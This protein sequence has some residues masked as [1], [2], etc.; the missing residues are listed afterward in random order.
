MLLLTAALAVAQARGDDWPEF[1]GPTG[2]GLVSG[3]RLPT[4]WSRTENVVWKQVIPGKGWSSPV[5]RGERVYLT[6]SVSSQRSSGNAHSLQAI[7]LDAAS[8]KV[9]WTKEVFEEQG[10]SAVAI[11]TK[12]SHASPT[13]LVRD[14]RVYVHFGHQ[15]T[16]CLDLSGEILWRNTSLRYAPVHG[17]GGSPILV[18]DALIF[19]CDGSDKRFVAALDRT[20]GQIRWTTPR[21]G[22][23][24]RPFSFSTPLAIS[25]EGR[26]QVVSPGSDMVAAYDVDDGHEIWRVRYDGYSVVPRPVYGH[27]LV[28]ICTG[29]NAS[30]LLAIRPTGHDDV[31]KTHVAWTSR[32]SM[33]LTPSPLLVG[34]ELYTVSD[35]GMATCLDAETGKVVWQER[36]GSA[37]SASPTYA[38]GRVYCQAEDGTC[39]VIAAARQFKT[40]AR[41]SLGERTLASHAASDGCLYIRTENHLYRIGSR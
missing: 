27:G 15:G 12:N 21:T 36:I 22:D 11:H 2:Q 16:A 6:T 14:G 30:S 35:N 10:A 40:L 39:V 34:D 4:Q 7:C 3:G 17:N 37:Y 31:T 18:G 9:L 26:T 38:D 33:P 13:P 28:Y 23:A 29:Y 5:V 24:E 1:R 19:S 20:T 8:G 41:N 25:V 32:R